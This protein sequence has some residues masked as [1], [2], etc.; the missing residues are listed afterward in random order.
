MVVIEPFGSAGPPSSSTTLLRASTPDS[1]FAALLD[2]D[3]A[4]GTDTAGRDVSLPPGLKAIHRSAQDD[5]SNLEIEP[6]NL[7]NREGPPQPG[8]VLPGAP[9]IAPILPPLA[10]L[11]G[12]QPRLTPLVPGARKASSALDVAAH[13]AADTPQNIASLSAAL[14]A[15]RQG[16]PYNGF[17]LEVEPHA[18]ERHTFAFAALGVFGRDGENAPGRVASLPAALAAARS[19]EPG[20]VFNL[21]IEPRNRAS[22]REWIGRS[23][24]AEPN[25]SMNAGDPAPSVGASAIGEAAS[26]ASSASAH[27]PVSAELQ[28][29]PVVEAST[30]PE[31]RTESAVDGAAPPEL[32]ARKFETSSASAAPVA[33]AL[34][35][36]AD[37]L[38]VS[39]RSA[40]DGPEDFARLRRIVEDTAAS[41]GFDVADIRLNG[42]PGS[43]ATMTGGS[44]GS[45]AR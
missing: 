43:F 28:T 38:S 19:G 9:A 17:N 7:G 1:S 31:A 34:S 14:T 30:L 11:D 37:A 13:G 16:T 45:R 26:A 23:A 44:R 35:G 6:I 2:R 24:S 40:T 5:A 42:D 27:S 10:R 32:W 18:Q 22:M 20:S 21:E 39:L 12:T 4:G 33:V 36:P 8:P 15:A 25:V 41:F 3:A 29:L